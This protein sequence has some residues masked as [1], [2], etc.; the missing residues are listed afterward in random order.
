MA[1]V[2]WLSRQ[3]VEAVGLGPAECINLVRK[4]LE[5]QARGLLEVPAKVGVHPPKGRHINA[6]PA[7]S[8]QLHTAGMKWVADFPRNSKLGLPTI[9]G[10]I[11]LN[12]ADNGIPICILE[13]GRITAIRTAAM[14]AISV[15]A[16]AVPNLHTATIVGTGVEAETHVM[17]IPK[18]LPSLK[19]IRVV[20]R[21]LKAA[22]EF[23]EKVGPRAAVTLYP[24]GEREDAIRTAEVVIT[25]TNAISEPLV[26]LEW[27][28]P[29]ATVVVL[30]N[31][32]KEKSLL[33]SMDRVIVDDRRPF[34]TEEVKRR[35]PRGVPDIDADIGEIL[36][37]KVEARKCPTD[38]V[39]VMNLG[40]AGC[41]LVV[42]HDLYMRAVELGLG[43]NLE[44]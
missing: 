7:F 10:I 32:G 44:F 36:S 6:M 25:V 3:D 29:G 18:A 34:A 22:T 23:C 43:T 33:Y 4:S 12:N 42:A 2:L 26:Q 11:V 21:S 24:F 38:R 28:S 5:W 20:G 40:S 15:L 1:H 9:Q 41:D 35:F 37:S 13:G 16:C 30:D 14:T 39:L 27:L 19:T 17:T 8:E 31:V